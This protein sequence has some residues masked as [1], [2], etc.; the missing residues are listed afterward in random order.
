MVLKREGPRQAAPGLLAIQFPQVQPAAQRRP[1]LQL[2]AS[3]QRHAVPQ[4]QPASLWL[5][6]KV[7]GVLVIVNLLGLGLVRV[8]GPIPKPGER[9]PLERNSY[10]ISSDAAGMPNIRLNVRLRCAE[11][12]KPASCAACVRLSPPA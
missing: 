5:V 6:R 2:Q 3:P 8:D 7:L 4:P 12:A 10:D 1:A 11:S 9:S